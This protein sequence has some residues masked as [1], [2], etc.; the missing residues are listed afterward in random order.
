MKEMIT[1]IPGM[2]YDT[3]IS[4]VIKQSVD[5][6][7]RGVS[8]DLQRHRVLNMSNMYREIHAGSPAFKGFDDYGGYTGVNVR[9]LNLDNERKWQEVSKILQLVC[10]LGCQSWGKF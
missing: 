1:S 3:D 9:I 4:E 6:W 5:I 8:T 2:A 7:S 10:V